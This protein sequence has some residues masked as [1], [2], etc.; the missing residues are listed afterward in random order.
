M[1]SALAVGRVGCVGC[2][3]RVGCVGSVG[4]CGEARRHQARLQPPMKAPMTWPSRFFG[5]RGWRTKSN[6]CR[7]SGMRTACH[8]STCG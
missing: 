4:C 1:P 3:G 2:V 8:S 6:K 5:G 7:W